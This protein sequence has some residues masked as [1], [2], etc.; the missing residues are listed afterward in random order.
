MGLPVTR[1]ACGALPPQPFAALTAPEG[2]GC[3][4]LP[5]T[6]TRG[7]LSLQAVFFA[8]YARVCASRR[9][10]VLAYGATRLW[11]RLWRTSAAAV[12]CAHG[13]PEDRG[14]APLPR[15]PTRGKLS[16]QAVFCALTRTCALRAVFLVLAHAATRPCARSRHSRSLRSR[17]PREGLRVPPSDSHPQQ[18]ELAGCLLCALRAGVLCWRTLPHAVCKKSRRISRRLLGPKRLDLLSRGLNVRYSPSLCNALIAYS[19]P[20]AAARRYQ[21]LAIPISRLTP[22]PIS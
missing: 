22:H 7:K 3:A 16:L 17:P 1:C 18:A 6:P 11:V 13:H 14:C 20:C 21:Y 5:R 19:S 9:C 15:T 10:F 4:P 12:R 8:R 2:R